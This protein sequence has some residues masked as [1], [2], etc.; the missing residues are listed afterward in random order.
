MCFTARTSLSLFIHVLDTLLSFFVAFSGLFVFSSLPPVRILLWLKKKKKKNYPS[1]RVCTIAT[2]RMLYLAVLFFQVFSNSDIA[3]GCFLVN[4]PLQVSSI[5]YL[6]GEAFYNHN[7][8]WSGTGQDID[9]DLQMICSYSPPEPTCITNLCKNADGFD[10]CEDEM[11]SAP[12]CDAIALDGNDPLRF[13]LQSQNHMSQTWRLM[14][15]DEDD[16][17]GLA[18]ITSREECL[19]A[20][21]ALGSTETWVSDTQAARAGCNIRNVV[22]SGDP[23][24]YETG[25]WTSVNFGLSTSLNIH[26]GSN[27]QLYRPVCK[28]MSR[29]ATAECI[30]LAAGNYSLIHQQYFDGYVPLDSNSPSVSISPSPSPSRSPGLAPGSINGMPPLNPALSADCCWDEKDEFEASAWTPPVKCANEG[31]ECVCD[32]WVTYGPKFPVWNGSPQPENNFYSTFAQGHN[33]KRA[34]GSITCE[35][36]EFGSDP[37][38]NR[39]KHCFCQLPARNPETPSVFPSRNL[40]QPHGTCFNGQYV[41]CF[42]KGIPHRGIDGQFVEIYSY[43]VCALS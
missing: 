31:E 14:S 39:E 41:R 23:L 4:S 15:C 30:L 12:F 11:F 34:Y 43:H 7:P 1:Y 19:A 13:V 3:P 21:Q 28:R 17:R 9:Q 22:S 10:G 38:P 36:Q 5:P 27:T 40:C 26:S 42:T 35:N 2:T 32:G 8:S 20:A 6:P 18:T 29:D 33:E 24:V 16:T 25:A 37:T